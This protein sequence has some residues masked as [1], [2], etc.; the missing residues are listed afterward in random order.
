MRIRALVLAGLL[1]GSFPVVAQPTAPE[2]AETIQVTASLREEEADTVAASVS[3]LTAAEAEAR[4]AVS[5]HELLAALPG[6]TLV[7]SGSPGKA[8][9]LFARGT[10][11]NQTLVLV[12]GVRLNEPLLG[13]FDWAFAMPEEIARVESVRGP[14]SVLYGSAAIG[15]VVQLLTR[16]EPGA[17][18]RLEGGER[19]YRRAG[20]A[21]GFVRGA[22]SGALSG[23][24]REGEG[25]LPNDG[26]DGGAGR[27]R[28]DWQARPGLTAGLAGRWQEAEIGL[29]YDFFGAPATERRQE[30]ELRHLALPVSWQTRTLTVSG[31]AARVE[32][33]VILADPHD[34]FAASRSEAWGTQ[35]RATAQRHLGEQW[36]LAAGAEWERQRASSADAFGGGLDGARERRSGGFVQT[37]WRG[38]RARVEAGVRRDDHD[39]FGGETSWRGGALVRVHDHLRLRAS[40]GEAFRAPSL[41]DLY[42]PGFGNP[43]LRP[44]RSRGAELGAEGEAGPWRLAAT[45]FENRLRDL[46]QFDFVSFL[47]FNTGRARTRGLELEAR[48]TFAA[49]WLRASATRLEAEDRA[50]GAPLLRR[51]RTAAALAGGVAA[52]QWALHGGV[53]YVGERTD[54][55]SIELAAYTVAEAGVSWQAT[56]RIQP[57][58]RVENLFDRAYEE[59]TGY[60]APGRTWIAGVAFRAGR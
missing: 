56:A 45:L 42:F 53:R 28:L 26:F 20:L 16:H 57:Y 14:F 34:P 52:G 55:G 32:Q 29:P 36:E 8:V 41:G 1:G 59:V 24:W 12:D 39:S 4:Q 46:V 60:P 38:A 48:A 35:L 11:S 15:G 33:E 23:A 58:A 49:G 31:S 22:L 54:V 25:E 27:L 21:T 17:T 13:G 7:Q 51:P 10:N 30:S 44:E 37:T 6:L 3:V 9:S 18:L 19:S 47:P 40:Y 2:Y 50:T 43:E 5:V